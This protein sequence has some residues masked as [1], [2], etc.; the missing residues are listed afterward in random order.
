VQAYLNSEDSKEFDLR[1]NSVILSASWRALSF[2]QQEM[3]PDSSCT[4]IRSRFIRSHGRKKQ[5]K[6]I[7]TALVLMLRKGLIELRWSP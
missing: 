2:H 4:R 6:T 5:I 7:I 3:T 1:F